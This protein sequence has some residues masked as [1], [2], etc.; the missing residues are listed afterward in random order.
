[1]ITLLL[2]ILLAALAVGGSVRAVLRDDRGTAPPP[3]SHRVDPESVPP[4]LRLD[5]R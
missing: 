3:A 1:M 4:A 5:L 2:L